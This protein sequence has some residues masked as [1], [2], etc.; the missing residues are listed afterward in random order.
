[1]DIGFAGHGSPS[2][3]RFPKPHNRT[4]RLPLRILDNATGT[5]SLAPALVTALGTI[6]QNFCNDRA[7]LGRN[8]RLAFLLGTLGTRPAADADVVERSDSSQLARFCASRMFEPRLLRLI[9][10]FVDARDAMSVS[11]FRLWVVSCGAGWSSSNEMRIKKI[12]KT[13]GSWQL[14]QPALVF[15]GFKRFY[16]EASI[17]RPDCVWSDLQ[18]HGFDEQFL[19]SDDRPRYDKEARELNAYRATASAPVPPFCRF[20]CTTPV[21]VHD[22]YVPFANLALKA[23]SNP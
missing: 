6:F 19:H 20:L 11:D 5:W 18:V 7:R 4:E 9:V 23:A 8:E 3:P 12:F 22:W 2:F 21:C 1:M 14:G 10:S 16:D 17:D 13:F 15:D